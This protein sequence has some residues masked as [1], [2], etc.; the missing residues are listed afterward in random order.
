MYKS[1]EQIERDYD[2]QWVLIINCERDQQGSLLGGE[3][4]LH[5][6]KMGN[7]AEKMNEVDNGLGPSFI[8]YIGKVPEDIYY[9]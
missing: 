6:E 4:V 7:I 8:G 5:N 2:G 1:L 9:L 3:V